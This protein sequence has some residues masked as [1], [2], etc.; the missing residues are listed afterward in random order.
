MQ[1]LKD[2]GHPF[3]EGQ[4]VFDITFE[5]VQAGERSNHLF[6]IANMKQAMVVGTSDLSE[7]ALG[8]ATYGV[9][10]H[11]AHYHVNASV[12]KSLMQHLVVW[13]AENYAHTEELSNTLNHIVHSEISPELIPAQHSGQ[14]Q[15]TEQVIG[16][17][18]IQD[19]H[20]YYLTRFGFSPERVAFMAWCA[21]HDVD[22][23]LWPEITLFHKNVY[24]IATI[25]HWLTIFVKRFFEQSQY[26]R[27]CIANA[28]KV[29]SGGSLSPRGDWRAPSDSKATLWLEKINLIPDH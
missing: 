11:M 19:F 21:W 26:K 28:P 3:A 5:N 14:V 15:S 8:W 13:W 24:D 29:G 17:Y 12:P 27:S 18:E 25:K 9:G 20:L 4:P 16:P 6:R 1:M 2:L 23:G 22:Q 10:D 7:L